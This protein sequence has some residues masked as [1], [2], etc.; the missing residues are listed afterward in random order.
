MSNGSDSSS[1]DGDFRVVA[2]CSGV[3]VQPE[4]SAVVETVTSDLLRFRFC[5]GK[6]CT[7]IA[8]PGGRYC[9]RCWEAHYRSK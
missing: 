5:A 8:E 7:R 9:L 3:A 1:G 2:V 6:M 4:E